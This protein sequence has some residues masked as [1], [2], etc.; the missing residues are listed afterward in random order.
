MCSNGIKL[1][2]PIQAAI[3]KYPRMHGLHT[4]NLV[5]MVLEAASL[6]SR[7]RHGLCLACYPSVLT[8]GT[9]WE[10]WSPP[11][12][13][14]LIFSCSPTP[15][16]F[17]QPNYL[18]KAPPLNIAMEVGLQHVNFEGHKHSVGNYLLKQC[19]DII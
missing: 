12:T 11:L 7:S 19:M 15:M 8:W 10:F 14:T 2:L 1:P 6:R 9:P 18:P 13:R 5:L 4:G 16:S 3:T 17:S